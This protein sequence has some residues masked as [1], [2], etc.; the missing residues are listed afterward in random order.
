M[1]SQFL[2]RDNWVAIHTPP[3]GMERWPCHRHSSLEIME[4]PSTPLWMEWRGGNGVNGFLDFHGFEWISIDFQGLLKI[5]MDF[6]GFHWFSWIS[7]DFIGFH[8]ISMDFK[9]LNR[10]SGDSQQI[11]MDSNGFHRI[12]MDFNGFHGI[13]LDFLGFQWISM[14]LGPPRAPFPTFLFFL[15]QIPKLRTKKRNRKGTLSY[16]SLFFFLDARI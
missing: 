4:L 7:I 2:L 11:S 5:S 13:S 14:D 10:I 12:P 15:L 8:N 1:P 16:F 9:G 3:N 6:P